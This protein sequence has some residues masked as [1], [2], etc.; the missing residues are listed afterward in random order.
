[1][2]QITNILIQA[3]PNN[4]QARY[5]CADALEQLG[6]QCESV[7]MAQRLFNRRPGA[8]GGTNPQEVGWI[9]GAE[10]PA[11]YVQESHFGLYEP[12]WTKTWPMGKNLPLF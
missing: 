3:D 5:L 1:M 4:L 2:A 11:L 12:W 6:Y 10:G 9:A 8:S 7:F